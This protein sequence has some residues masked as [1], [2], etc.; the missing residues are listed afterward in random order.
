MKM[1]IKSVLVDDQ[2]NAHKFYTDVLGFLTKHNIEFGDHSWITLVSPEDKHGVE[3]SLE[4]N[5]YP[6]ARE[7]Q[8]ALKRDGIP[9]TQFSVND[10][11]EEYEKLVEAGVT[12]SA[13]P[14]EVGDVK[15]ATFDDTCGNLIQ[16]VEV[17]V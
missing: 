14:K 15:Y 10:V 9:W 1:H 6:A 11:Q 12:F 5:E 16:L 17:P 8:I 3:L 4:P 7:L 13:P 2:T